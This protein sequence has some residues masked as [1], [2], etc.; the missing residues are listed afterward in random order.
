MPKIDPFQV[1]PNQGVKNIK[2]QKFIAN[3]LFYAP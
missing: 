1:F 2:N 3:F